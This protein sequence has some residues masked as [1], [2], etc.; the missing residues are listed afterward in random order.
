MNPRTNRKVLDGLP[1]RDWQA[2]STYD[3]L[4]IVPSGKMHDSGYHLIAIVGCRKN[5]PV[6]IAAYCDD[7]GVHVPMPSPRYGSDKQFSNYMF[8]VDMS[9]PSGIAHWWGAK[10]TVGTAL[11]STD[12]TVQY[13]GEV[14]TRA[15]REAEKTE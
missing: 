4:M 12:V 7:I 10:F 5:V 14:M 11:S 1:V 9:Y 3:S 15:E 6:E 13:F 8:R 2:E